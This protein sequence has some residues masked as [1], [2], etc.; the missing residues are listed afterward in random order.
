MAIKS[1]IKNIIAG[2]AAEE[3]KRKLAKA[4]PSYE[5]WESRR[6]FSFA[7]AKK[8]D[9]NITAFSYDEISEAVL[10]SLT[11]AESEM[12]EDRI[13]VFYSSEGNLSSCAKILIQEYFERDPAIDLLYG[14]EDDSHTPFFK[15]DWSPDR[16]CQCFYIGSVYA[17]RAGFLRKVIN[18]CG[19]ELSLGHDCRITADVLFERLA[20]AAGGFKKRRPVTD[21]GIAR[22]ALNVFGCN[23]MNFPIGHIDEILFHRDTEVDPYYGRGPESDRIAIGVSSTHAPDVSEISVIIPSKDNPG[24]LKQCIDSLFSIC[25]EGRY[26]E[27]ICVDNGS[28][29]SAKKDIELYFD[30]MRK[31]GMDIRYLYEKS[32]FNFSH[33]CNSGAE[34]A[35]GRILLFLNDDTEFTT[36]GILE[37]MADLAGRPYAGAVGAKLLYPCGET[38]EESAQLLKRTADDI[39][40]G[41]AH[42]LQH[43]GVVN[44]RMNPWHILKGLD[45]RKDHYF[46]YNRGVLN[47]SAVTGACL[48]LSKERFEMMGGFSEE[49][50]VNFNDTDLCYSC[51]EAGFYNIECNDICLIHHESVSRGNDELSEAAMER[52]TES[53]AVLGKRHPAM[54]NEDPFYSRHFNKATGLWPFTLEEE[55]AFEAMP[56]KAADKMFADNKAAEWE[57][58]VIR[59]GIDNAGP[60]T[61]HY[62][63]GLPDRGIG[64]SDTEAAEHIKAKGSLF[65]IDGY[66]FIIGSDNAVFERRLVLKGESGDCKGHYYTVKPEDIYR[67]DIEANTPDQINTAM[68]GFRTVIRGEDLLPGTYRIGI[69]A[70]SVMGRM[71]LLGFGLRRLIL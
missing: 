26:P 40:E 54:M 38:S 19:E 50:P 14:D 30:I 5:E 16:F 2:K 31:K 59:V 52:L 33:M 4:L 63:P 24:L 27:I 46:G 11:S 15:P 6:E 37:E 64:Y 3:Y 71:K 60:F 49:L 65:Y 25:K 66:S 20:V 17:V 44:V 10:R 53:Q 9:I 22:A 61:D 39:S 48:M 13:I 56:V 12:T 7:S 28:A 1:I 8:N 68:A 36:E 41:G 57:N 67:K 45:D 55:P 58:G 47:V 69:I 18:D 42:F 35:K 32:P 62:K 23:E 34:T 21:E 29:E 43:A 51:L 70:S